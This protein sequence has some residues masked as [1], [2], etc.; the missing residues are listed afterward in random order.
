MA[1][2]AMQQIGWGFDNKP[3]NDVM[4]TTNTNYYGRYL[5]LLS[6]ATNLDPA[7]TNPAHHQAFYIDR[8]TGEFHLISKSAGG[9]AGNGSSGQ[10]Q[11]S[12]DGRYIIFRS[13]AS[14]LVPNDTNGVPD[15]FLYDIAGDS[16]TLV[17]RSHDGSQANGLSRDPSICADGSFLTYTSEATNI[18]PGDINGFRDAFLYDVIHDEVRI[19][20]KPLSGQQANGDTHKSVISLD[21]DSV[22]F[23]TDAS[24]FFPNDNNNARDILWAELVKPPA[25]DDSTVRMT[26]QA[27]PGGIVTVTVHVQN[28]GGESGTASVAVPLPPNTSYVPASVTNGGSYNAGQETVNWQGNVGAQAE[29][30][31][32]FQME[33]DAGLASFT[34]ISLEAAISGDNLVHAPD[35]VTVVNPVS[36]IYLP[37]L[38]HQPLP[39]PPYLDQ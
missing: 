10:P 32:S 17:S 24:N 4:V 16:L 12:L 5:G 36:G 33:I 23:A 39:L 22:V 25:F 20:S 19:I 37:W 26:G 2:G 7:A 13:W 18:I 38:Q 28:S 14:N 9:A 6:H 35:A 21:C 1:T 30:S 31:F 29:N 15:V 34:L 27:D 3:P 11:V 8:V